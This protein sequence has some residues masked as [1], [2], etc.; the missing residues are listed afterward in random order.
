MT[1]FKKF[2]TACAVLAVATIVLGVTGANAANFYKSFVSVAD[3]AGG[4]A[5]VT[6]GSLGT[7]D[8]VGVVYLSTGTEYWFYDASATDAADATH[9]RCKGYAT[10]GVWEQIY[11]DG[12]T[13]TGDNVRAT[14]PTI[15]SPTLT[16]PTLGVADAT[17]VNTGQG[18][19]E[20]YAMNQDVETTDPVAFLNVTA[21]YLIKWNTSEPASLSVGVVYGADGAT[22]DPTGT[23]QTSNHLVLYASDSPAEW[24][25]VRSADGILYFDNIWAPVMLPSF[26]HYAT[27][28][29]AY[30]DTAT[31][32]VLL[33]NEVYG[34][35]I[36]NAG[37]ASAR[38]YTTPAAAHGF[39]FM[40][41]IV[42]AENFDLEP[43]SSQQFWLNGSQMAAGEHIQNTAGNK[44]DIMF[45]WSAETGDGTFEIFCKSDSANFVQ[46]TP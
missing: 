27:A 26:S 1:F 37:A 38:V 31:P 8:G 46:A 10:S 18:D 41:M 5:A 25:L 43:Y 40:V 36:T 21:D 44:G 29:N 14:A 12:V 32:H 20:L 42:A 35:V 2:L 34:S 23:S 9:I 22:W 30:N 17:T 39:N 3:E 7:K 45:C 16:T 24:L 28:E 15:A 33:L 6:C 11:D 13:G 4:I 19:Y